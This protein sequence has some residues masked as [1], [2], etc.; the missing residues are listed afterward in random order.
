M[1]EAEA[2]QR[3]RGCD[4]NDWPVLA[5]AVGLPCAVWTED[6][7]FFGTGI[8]AWTTSRIEI[9]LEGQTRALESEEDP[10]RVALWRRTSRTSPV[11]RPAKKQ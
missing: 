7:D 11:C 2:R 6:S 4:E 1:F 8:A 9:V 5:A 3:L 10:R